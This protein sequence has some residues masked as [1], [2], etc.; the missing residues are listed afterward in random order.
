[1]RNLKPQKKKNS[2]TYRKINLISHR[3]PN[4]LVNN[5]HAFDKSVRMTE[6]STSKEAH[7]VSQKGSKV[8]KRIVREYQELIKNLISSLNQSR[9]YQ[10]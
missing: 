3:S 7:F 4:R 1:M 6:E 9:R 10:T 8:M 5:F 2:H